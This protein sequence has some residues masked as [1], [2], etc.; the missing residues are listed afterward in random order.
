MKVQTL[1]QQNANAVFLLTKQWLNESMSFTDCLRS[2]FSSQPL[3]CSLAQVLADHLL[4][5]GV[6]DDKQGCGVG[7][8]VGVA[9]SRS[10][11]VE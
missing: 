9:S 4:D 7:A 8:G 11:W 5:G 1:A 2:R 3:R 6:D 10:S